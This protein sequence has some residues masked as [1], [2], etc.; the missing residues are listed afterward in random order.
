[1]N[2]YLVFRYLHI[3]FLFLMVGSV[4][5]QQFMIAKE[6][7]RRELNRIAK[8]DLWY[9]VTAII[10]VGMGLTLWFGVGKPADYYT[11][12]HLFLLKTGLFIMVGLLSVYPTL[13]FRNT[14]KS[15]KENEKAQVPRMVILVVRLELFLLL[16]IPLLAVMM[17]SGMGA[18][19]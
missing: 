4:V 6:M 15:L 8:A 9:G 13:Y 11:Y 10:V 17:A 14:R 2:L 12:N 18:V 19:N 7:S 3:L 16:I 5:A 1:M